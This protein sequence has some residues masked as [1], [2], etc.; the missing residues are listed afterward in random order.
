MRP[1]GHE[2]RQQNQAARP[3]LFSA[4]PNGVR[5]VNKSGVLETVIGHGLVRHKKAGAA[6]GGGPQEGRSRGQGGEQRRRRG[7]K[8]HVHVSRNGRAGTGKIHNI[9]MNGTGNQGMILTTF[10]GS[11]AKFDGSKA[12]ITMVAL[13]ARP[14]SLSGSPNT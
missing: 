14:I 6:H 8:T 9:V 1:C 4:D 10:A 11:I 12:R 2:A 7:G 5:R 3:L 13:R